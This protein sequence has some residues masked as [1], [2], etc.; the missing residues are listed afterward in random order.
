MD[1]WNIFFVTMGVTAVLLGA[2]DTHAG[3]MSKDSCYC[4]DVTWGWDPENNCW[5][6]PDGVANFYD[7]MCLNQ[8]LEGTAELLREA[9]LVNL[10]E[11]LA[12]VPAASA[13][14]VV[15]HATILHAQKLKVAALLDSD[16]AGENAARQETLVHTL[17]NKGILRTKDAYSGCVGKPEI[18]DL[19]RDTLVRVAKEELGWDIAATAGKQS[20]RPIVDVFAAEVPAFSKYK[21]A[22][23]FLRWTRD[24]K[25][26]GL[27]DIERTHWVKLIELINRALK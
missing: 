5:G 9:R 15:Y 3:T 8:V 25:A 19:L 16:A 14:K 18:E 12:L 1:V 24:H 21:L 13:G 17:G 23:A 27:T 26:E 4:T 7:L 2:T 22:K 11:K 10:N 6:Q 20:T